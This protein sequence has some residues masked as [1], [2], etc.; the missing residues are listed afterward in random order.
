MEHWQCHTPIRP[1]SSGSLISCHKT[2]EFYGF[3]SIPLLLR[4]WADVTANTTFVFPSFTASFRCRMILVSASS[5]V[6]GASP[7][8]SLDWLQSTSMRCVL[9]ICLLQPMDTIAVL[10]SKENGP[11]FIFINVQ[12]LF[13]V[14]RNCGGTLYTSPNSLSSLTFCLSSLTF[15]VVE[16]STRLLTPYPLLL[17][18]SAF[19]LSGWHSSQTMSTRL[20]CCVWDTMYV[21]NTCD[22]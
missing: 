5:C 13:Q 15:C 21:R 11:T 9:I 17:F 1:E 22:T 19:K 16:R 14:S 18:V 10:P 20:A 4:R 6:H 12:K 3:K 7:E 2:E 8:T